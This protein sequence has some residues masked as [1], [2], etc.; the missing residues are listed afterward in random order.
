VTLI[1]SVLGQQAAQRGAATPAL[2]RAGL[3]RVFTLGDS[4]RMDASGRAGVIKT[5]RGECTKL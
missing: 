1:W 4:A 2:F 5:E 3:R